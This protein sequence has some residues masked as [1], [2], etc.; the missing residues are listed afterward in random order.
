L[1]LTWLQAFVAAHVFAINLIQLYV[2]RRFGFM[3]IYG[4]RFVYY[5]C[6]HVIWGY[7]RLQLIF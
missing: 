2:F 1:E 6:W 3:A 5:A 7:L 4:F